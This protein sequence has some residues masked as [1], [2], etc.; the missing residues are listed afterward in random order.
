MPVTL[1]IRE[2][3]RVAYYV[4]SD[5]WETRDLV[6]LYPEDN[7]FRDGVNHLVHTFMNVS[8]VRRIPS[9]I[10]SAR[11]N[12]PAF[13]HRNSGQLIMIGARTLPRVVTETICRLARYDRVVFF[14]TEEEGWAYVN[15]LL[16]S[17]VAS[18]R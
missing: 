18:V 12:A 1:N 17:E 14:A 11:F 6:S 10:I 9:N 3:G 16:G 15:K 13:T 5:P 8:G 7:R 2:D 4:L